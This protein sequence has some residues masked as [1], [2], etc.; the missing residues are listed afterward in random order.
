MATHKYRQR[1]P[2][3]IHAMLLL[4]ISPRFGMMSFASMVNLRKLHQNQ[5]DVPESED[6]SEDYENESED[7]E[8]DYDPESEPDENICRRN[9]TWNNKDLLQEGKS[10]ADDSWIDCRKRMGWKPRDMWW[11]HD[12]SSTNK[13]LTLEQHAQVRQCLEE[14]FDVARQE[15]VYSWTLYVSHLYQREIC[16]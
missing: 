9:P 1:L 3:C 7:Y 6:E 8:I 13:F 15:K 11:K 2:L 5:E 12:N 14:A 10:E 4:S 16:M